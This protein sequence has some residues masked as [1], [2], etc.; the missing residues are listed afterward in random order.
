MSNASDSDIVAGYIGYH[1]MVLGEDRVLRRVIETPWAVELVGDL[2]YDDPD[3][4][5]ALL[6]A[7]A[8]EHPADDAMVSLGV[9]LGSLLTEHPGAIEMIE[10]DVR[11]D[12]A[13]SDL[14]TWIMEDEWISPEIWRRIEALSQSS[15]GA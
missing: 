6:R 13:L 5:W 15:P 1:R 4:C 10:S 12:S 3:R 2:A 8:K 14:L 9:T 11:R 7:I